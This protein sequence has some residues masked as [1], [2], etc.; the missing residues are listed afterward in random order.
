VKVSSPGILSIGGAMSPGAEN[1]PE[2]TD[3]FRLV[4]EDGDVL[5]VG[6]PQA[7]WACHRRG[8]RGNERRLLER[9]ALDLGDSAMVYGPDVG[10]DEEL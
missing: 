4:N 7:R 3:E 8:Y 10:S 1:R 5:T 9:V 2:R 6:S